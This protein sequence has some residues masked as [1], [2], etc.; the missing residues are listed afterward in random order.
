MSASSAPIAPA[1]VTTAAMT[2]TGVSETP[3]R[4][5]RIAA[6]AIDDS[7][8]TCARTK[9]AC[10]G[11]VSPMSTATSVAASIGAARIAGAR[12][13]KISTMTAAPKSTT[14]ARGAHS[15]ASAPGAKI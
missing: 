1:I 13:A 9:S 8:W 10:V 2:T 11:R 12:A 6:Y 7:A 15:A 14:N 4:L 3:R 5:A